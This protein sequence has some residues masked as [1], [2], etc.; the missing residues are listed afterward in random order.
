MNMKNGNWA[1]G[2]KLN[3]DIVKIK[4]GK[5]GSGIIDKNIL[6]KGS[7][8]LIHQIFLHFGYE[9]CSDFHDNLQNIVINFLIRSGFS[10]GL[11]DL[12]ADE[13]TETEIKKIIEDK[14]RQVAEIMASLHTATFENSTAQTNKQLFEKR[15]NQVLNN[16]NS[17]AG[18]IGRRSLADDN[19]MTNMVKAGS[20]GS[21][22]NIAQMVACLGQ[23]NV[24]GARIPYGFTGRTLPHFRR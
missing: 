8:G 12:I 14:K 6:T 4:A 11:S 1:D 7:K 13:A 20:K 3:A 24:D 22:L 2:G 16:A 21:N 10:V 17:E 23:V 5:N 9:A 18:K 15:A 19:R